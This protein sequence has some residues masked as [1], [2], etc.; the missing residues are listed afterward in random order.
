MS[1]ERLTDQERELLR[2]VLAR[3]AQSADA[4]DGP[5]F[6]AFEAILLARRTTPN[7][8]PLREAWAS[9]VDFASKHS[10][11]LSTAADNPLAPSF[12]DDWCALLDRLRAVL[13]ATD[14][15]GK[16]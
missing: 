5:V 12:G 6:E 10:A 14:T 4:H 13:D 1:S 2:P 9:V 7:E 15:E 16:S 11:S 8:T 3:Y